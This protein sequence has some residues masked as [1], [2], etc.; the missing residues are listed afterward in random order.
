MITIAAIHFFAVSCLT[1]ASLVEIPYG[2][3]FLFG[4]VAGF[5]KATRSFVR[6]AKAI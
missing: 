1:I 5:N 4:T 3:Q 6:Y 2:Y